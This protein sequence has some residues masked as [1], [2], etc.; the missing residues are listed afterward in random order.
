MTFPYK[1]LNLHRAG[2]QFRINLS[3]FFF[4]KRLGWFV[5]TRGDTV[6]SE[7][8]VAQD[9]VVGPFPNEITARDFVNQK[10]LN[11][12]DFLSEV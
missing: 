12:S 8:V 1:Q 10:L 5:H 4:V 7:G 6:L 3:R 9:G 11:T 2:K